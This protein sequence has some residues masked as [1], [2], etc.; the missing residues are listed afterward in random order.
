MT[1]NLDPKFHPVVG[2]VLAKSGDRPYHGVRIVCARINAGGGWNAVHVW[3]PQSEYK[4]TVFTYAEWCE[5]AK[6]ATVLLAQPAER[7][8]SGADCGCGGPAPLDHDDRCNH[9]GRTGYKLN[10]FTS[11]YT[12]LCA[13]CTAGRRGA[14]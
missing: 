5:W 2:D 11:P 1:G 12:G 10:E 3:E 14:V 4:P 7:Y 13:R 9:C 6:G 8:C